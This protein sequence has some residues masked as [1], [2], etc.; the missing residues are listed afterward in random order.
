MPHTTESTHPI[1]AEMLRGLDA[2]Q[3]EFYEE[4]AGILQYDANL[5]RAQAEA[6]ALLEVIRRDGWPPRVAR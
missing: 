5:S 6:L 2:T 3:R 1:V 4:R